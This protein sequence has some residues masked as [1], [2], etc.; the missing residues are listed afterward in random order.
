MFFTYS[1]SIEYLR[2]YCKVL[3]INCTY[4]TNSAKMPLF[5]VI[6]VEATGKSFCVY[7]EF[8][9]REEEVDYVR[10]LSHLK[11]MLGD[12][13]SKVILTDKSDSIRNTIATVFPTTTS[14]LCI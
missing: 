7:F 12:S 13:S 1:F 3:I 2:L 10:A 5:E 8:M 6:G 14:L 9:L 11:E 4:N